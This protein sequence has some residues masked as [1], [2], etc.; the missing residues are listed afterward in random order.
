MHQSRLHHRR[1][2]RAKQ[3]QLAGDFEGMAMMQEP[4]HLEDGDAEE[5]DASRTD[6][7]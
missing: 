2:L 6:E 5:V 7:L 4:M 1:A 3:M